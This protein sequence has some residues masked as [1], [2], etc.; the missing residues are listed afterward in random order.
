MIGNIYKN[1]GDYEKAL[2]IYRQCFELRRELKDKFGE[3]VTLQR[4]GEVFFL[5]G[6]YAQSSVLFDSSSTIWS[7]LNDAKLNVWTLSWW[8]GSDLRSGEIESASIKV[9]EVEN[10]MELTDPHDR[11]VIIVNWNLSS[12]FRFG[13][14]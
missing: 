6:N 4:M 3:G 2:K 8:G 11:D 1:Q 9:E 5:L 7:E 14:Q 10:M 13:E 12:V